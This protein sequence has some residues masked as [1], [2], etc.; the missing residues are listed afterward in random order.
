MPMSPEVA[1]AILE[2]KDVGQHGHVAD[3]GTLVDGQDIV[4]DRIHHGLPDETVQNNRIVDPARVEA[5][6]SSMFDHNVARQHSC[7]WLIQ[8]GV[9]LGIAQVAGTVMNQIE[10]TLATW[11]IKVTS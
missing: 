2:G 10:L 11:C 9:I 7:Y 3:G 6:V 5:T 1:L 8:R 4:K